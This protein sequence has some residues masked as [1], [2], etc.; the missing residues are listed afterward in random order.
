MR[1]SKA[2]KMLGGHSA[3]AAAIGITYQAVEKWPEVLS[4]RIA[5][6]VVAALARR[7]LSPEM[8]GES[9][10]KKARA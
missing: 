7:H 5:D 10:A 2:L 8:L 9:K 3:T 6:R 1:K 4:P